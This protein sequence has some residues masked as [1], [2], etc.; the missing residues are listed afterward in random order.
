MGGRARVAVIG[1]VLV[2]ASLGVG[3]ITVARLYREAFE[4]QTQRL[5]EVAQSRARIIEAVARFDSIHSPGYPGGPGEATLA[6]LREAHGRFPGFGRTGEYVLARRDGDRIVFL[7]RHRGDSVP[8]PPDVDVPSGPAQPMRRALAG[9][10]GTMVG[11]DY[12]GHR[13]LAAYE[14]V[15]VLHL[16]LV[17]KIDLAEVRAPYIRAAV[18]VAGGGAVLI[19]LGLVGVHTLGGG[20]VLRMEKLA[21]DERRA[22]ERLRLVRRTG[23][24]GILEVDIRESRV[25]LGP[26]LCRLLGEPAAELTVSPTEFLERVHPDDRG[27]MVR[28]L[29]ETRRGEAPTMDRACRIRRAD[30]GYLSAVAAVQ[31]V[32]WDD[33]GTPVRL[34]GTIADV[35]ALEEARDALFAREAHLRAAQEMGG[36]GSWEWSRQDGSMWWSDELYRLL[37]STAGSVPPG[38]QTFLDRVHPDDREAVRLGLQDVLEGDRAVEA[39]FRVVVNGG[40]RWMRG[41]ARPH[42]DARGLPGR[43]MGFLQDVTEAHLM[44]DRLRHTQK[45]ETLGLLSGGIAHDF[46]NLLTAIQANVDLM[47]GTLP[48]GAS[49]LAEGLQEIRTASGLGVDMVRK[50][51]SFSRSNLENVRVVDVGEVLDDTRSLLVRLLPATVRLN[52]SVIDSPLHCN[53]DRA[54]FQEIVLNLVTNA[55]DAMAGRGELTVEARREDTTAGPRVMIRVRDT[56]SGIDA[57]SLTHIFEPFYTSK[58]EG[59]GTGLGLA[60]VDALM[61]KQ[62][63][64]VWAE[65]EPG[66]GTT[67]TLAFPAVEGP[68]QAARPEGGGREDLRGAER[69]LLVEDDPAIRRAGRTILGRF[70]YVVTAVPDGESA[71]AALL[72][73]DTVDLVVS[74]V[75]LPLISGIELYERTRSMSPRPRF[76]LM[77]GYGASE[78]AEVGGVRSGLR[79]LRKPWGVE[80]L[81]RAVR[82]ALDEPPVEAREA[83]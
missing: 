18:A 41:G 57:E 59:R 61:E 31:P 79:F 78:L 55:R 46:N 21:E 19:L 32:T 2:V 63:G 42:V 81:L 3:G 45:M 50:L 7:L 54:A 44:A 36:I 74:D 1:L 47:R 11:L 39:T 34:V 60:M 30:G 15:D 8:R 27:E 64:R 65:S 16:G 10:S 4:Q 13:V 28:Q 9:E 43:T 56:G 70:G 23:R 71:L 25:V 52:L 12:D 83:G 66:R 5:V 76:L 17:A 75:M 58:S 67:F 82:V 22:L 49:E 40:V 6:Q 29:D 33:A 14:P 69:I 37:G 68:V 35:T 53:I 48:P 26:D 38:A 77:S 73:E 24:V 62:G 20:L 51:M 72:A 80:E